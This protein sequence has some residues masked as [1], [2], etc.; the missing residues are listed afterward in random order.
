MAICEF[1][2]S[3]SRSLSRPVC[4]TPLPDPNHNPHIFCSLYFR[5]QEVYKCCTSRVGT[6]GKVSHGKRCQRALL[7]HW[8][9]HHHWNCLF[10]QVLVITLFRILNWTTRW[11]FKKKHQN[12][13]EIVIKRWLTLLHHAR[14]L[15]WQRWRGGNEGSVTLLIMWKCRQRSADTPRIC[16]GETI[17]F[18]HFCSVNL[19]SFFGPTCAPK[20]PGCVISILL[21]FT[22]NMNF[23]VFVQ[24]HV[25][26]GR[27]CHNKNMF[28]HVS[29]FGVLTKKF[30]V[31]SI[32]W[33]CWFPT[34]P[35]MHH[36]LVIFI[37]WC[38][39]QKVAVVFIFHLVFLSD[40]TTTTK[41]S[42]F[43]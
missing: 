13:A 28:F 17:I 11:L 5:M 4:P 41:W 10:F 36:I 23:L 24:F 7:D 25:Y 21:L 29:F 14:Q 38:S 8:D 18:D 37:F 42:W 19:W 20:W 15:C 32:C 9:H 16:E 22:S 35:P 34:R 30:R 2:E 43:C 3:V 39:S 6:C 31:F 27:L 12:D 33:L 40:P 26:C 1:F